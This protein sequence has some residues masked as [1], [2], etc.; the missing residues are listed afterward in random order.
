MSGTPGI[1][2]LRS[3]QLVDRM[4]DTL[5]LTEVQREELDRILEDNR[6]KM[7]AL[8]RGVQP[9]QRAISDSAR[10]AVEVLLTQKQMRRLNEL[11][12]DMRMRPPRGGQRGGGPRRQPF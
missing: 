4:A 12:G 3:P 2:G 8:R 5:E 7:M 1:V 6:Q 10:K 9:R 11:R